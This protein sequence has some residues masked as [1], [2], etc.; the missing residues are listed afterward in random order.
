MPRGAVEIIEHREKLTVKARGARVE[1][2]EHYQNRSGRPEEALKNAVFA[3]ESPGVKDAPC[4]VLERLWKVP[5]GPP[6]E[7]PRS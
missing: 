1:L 2:A 6:R 3:V 4:S 5:G 7:W